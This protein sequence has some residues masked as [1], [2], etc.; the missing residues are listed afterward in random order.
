MLLDYSQGS[1]DGA[2]G[3]PLT[4]VTSCVVSE[5]SLL[6]GD[7]GDLNGSFALESRMDRQGI[8]AAEGQGRVLVTD[9]AVYAVDTQGGG[10]FGSFTGWYVD[11]AQAGVGLY[12]WTAPAHWNGSA[13]TSVAGTVQVDLTVSTGASPSEAPAA[14]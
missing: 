4:E 2:A 11:F 8:D 5:M 6:Q 13:G 10:D 1:P 12:R 14:S 7:G 9:Q 3:G